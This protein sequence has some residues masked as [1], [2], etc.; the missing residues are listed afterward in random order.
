MRLVIAAAAMAACLLAACSDVP[1]VT[2]PACSSAYECEI[3]AYARAG[4]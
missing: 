4:R 2:G 1:R 3:Q